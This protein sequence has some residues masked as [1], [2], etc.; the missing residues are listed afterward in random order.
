MARPRKFTRVTDAPAGSLRFAKTGRG[1]EIHGF[2]FNTS[3]KTY[4]TIDDVT[5]KRQYLG[6]DL[7]SAVAAIEASP[8]NR[9]EDYDVLDTDIRIK[10]AVDEP[11]QGPAGKEH[12]RPNQKALDS[13]LDFVRH[14]AET[15]LSRPSIERLSDCLIT[16]VDWMSNDGAIYP[17]VTDHLITGQ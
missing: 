14:H 13:I 12:H 10:R 5:G 1:Q 16:W 11:I 17:R 4:Y 8:T 15:P 2:S 7:G 6:R 9:P 3:N